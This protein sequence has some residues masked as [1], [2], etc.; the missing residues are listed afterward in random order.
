M[1]YTRASP[2]EIT[3]VK[4]AGRAV[5]SYWYWL[6]VVILA[7]HCCVLTSCLWHACSVSNLTL[8]YVGRDIELPSSL[9]TIGLQYLVYF[10]IH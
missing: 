3:A 4:V 2:A 10:M 8:I 9:D 5:A 6:C 1:I 7:F